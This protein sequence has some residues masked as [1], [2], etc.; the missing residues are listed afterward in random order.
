M[1]A[2]Y[3][4]DGEIG[5]YI[6]YLIVGGGGGGG[7]NI[8]DDAGGGGA[9]G[10]RSSIAGNPTANYASP[11]PRLWLASGITYQAGVGSGGGLNNSGNDSYFH[12]IV[13]KGGGASGAHRVSGYNGGSG[14]GGNG[15]YVSTDNVRGGYGWYGQGNDGGTK[16]NY[17]GGGGGGGAA[18]AGQGGSGTGKA[19]GAGVWSNVETGIPSRGSNEDANPPVYRAG[20]GGAYGGG[21]GGNG[22]GGNGWSSSSYPTSGA[23]NTGGGGGGNKENHAYSANVQGGSGIV[24]LKVHNDDYTGVTTGSPTV[25]TVG[26]YKIIKFTSSGSYTA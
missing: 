6:E 1:G 17:P 18:E 16:T 5:Y 12:T 24:I 14:G 9:G 21:S 15:L 25:T 23:Q 10:Y 20:G 13:S 26:D 2:S 19:G 3:G 11:E 8:Y 7:N 22:G 4:P